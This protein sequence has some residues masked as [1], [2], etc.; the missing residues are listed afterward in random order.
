[1]A[2]YV[3]RIMTTEGEKQIDYGALANIP[4]QYITSLDEANLVNLRDLATGSYVLYGY[5]RPF[6]GS[7]NTLTI[8]T[9]LVNVVRKS[10]GSHV[11]IF[12]TLNSIVNFLEIL[13]DSSNSYG[14]TY[15]RT[16]IKMLDLHGLI[17]KVGDLSGLQTTAKDNLVTAINE[18]VAGGG[19][20]SELP[21]FDLSEMG[22]ADVV[23]GGEAVSLSADMTDLRT[24]L[25][26]GSI[27]I[28]FVLKSGSYSVPSTGVVNGLHNVLTDE[29]QI[30]QFGTLNGTHIY[31]NAIVKTNSI[32]IQADVDT[33]IPSGGTAGQVLTMGSDGK[34]VWADAPSG[35]GESGNVPSAEGVGF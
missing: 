12:S 20:S 34:A 27:K 19:G 33:S 2:D 9:Q 29:Y 13:V 21:Y 11:L 32:T 23:L 35:G 26:N 1:M 14:F 24:A 28:K 4:I 5:F 15:T 22:V 31:V 30:I 10:A 25:S 16:D 6:A 8:D 18:V 3:R 17:A 7:P